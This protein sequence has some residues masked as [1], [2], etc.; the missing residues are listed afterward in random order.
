[1][2]NVFIFMN[3]QALWTDSAD[4]SQFNTFFTIMW[5]FIDQTIKKIDQSIGKVIVAGL[6][7]SLWLMNL[8]VCV[9]VMKAQVLFG[10]TSDSS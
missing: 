1:M 6:V 8:C 5:Q 9:N 4:S 3:M 10:G 2:L 7:E